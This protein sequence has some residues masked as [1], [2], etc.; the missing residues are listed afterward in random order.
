[1]RRG[2][3]TVLPFLLAGCGER[4]E[5]FVRPD[6]ITDFKA[7]YESNCSGCHGGDGRHGAARPLNDPVF[8][9]VIGSET[10]RDVIANGRPKTA[11]PPFAQSSGGG[12]TD[13]QITILAD[14]I[15]QHWSR[16]QEFTNASLPRYRSEPG[17][18][19]AG[20]G[21]F[22]AYCAGCH[23]EEGVTKSKVGS[24]TDANFLALVSDQSLRTSVIAGRS[25]RGMP[26]WRGHPHPMSPQEISD[27]VA[28]ISAHRTPVN[29]TQRGPNLP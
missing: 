22:R 9:A 10:L 17:D 15:Q 27:V 29:L 8:L 12:L 3:L 5:Q 28:W 16:P 2:L 1:M 4:V 25:D 18:P 11:M 23:G 7:L 19:I 13:R 20:G 6:Q 14:Q 21:V 26:D 24:V